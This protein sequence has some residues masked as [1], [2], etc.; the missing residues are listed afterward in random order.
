MGW[1]YRQ[2][3]QHKCKLPT[4]AYAKKFDIWQCDD[5]ACQKEW[6]VTKINFDQRDGDWL[7]FQ[8]Y[9]SWKSGPFAPGT[10]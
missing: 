6:I 1:I 8:E 2:A 5:P 7:S 4:Y 9:E 10:K 3:D